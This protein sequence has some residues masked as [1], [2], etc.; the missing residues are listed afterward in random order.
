[1]WAVTWVRKTTNK[2]VTT[3]VKTLVRLP[4]VFPLKPIAI[5]TLTQVPLGA[6]APE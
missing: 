5:L 3:R 4:A 1:M 6:T 2:T